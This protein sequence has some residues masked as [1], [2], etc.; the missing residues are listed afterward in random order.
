MMA[1]NTHHPCS[2]HEWVL[3]TIGPNDDNDNDNDNERGTTTTTGEM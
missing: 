1:T 3:M 2:E